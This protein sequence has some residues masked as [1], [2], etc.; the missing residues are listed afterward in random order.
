VVNYVPELLAYVVVLIISILIQ[1]VIIQSILIQSS[2]CWRCSLWTLLL[3]SMVSPH[4]LSILVRLTIF[5]IRS[6]ANNVGTMLVSFPSMFHPID[7]NQ[8]TFISQLLAYFLVLISF[9]SINCF[10]IGCSPRVIS[11]LPC[12]DNIIR[13]FLYAS[14]IYSPFFSGIYRSITRV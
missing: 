3:M 4:L 7:S 14:C 10:M 13:I 11:I 5:S 6:C 1:S 2:L 12:T 9:G 8:R